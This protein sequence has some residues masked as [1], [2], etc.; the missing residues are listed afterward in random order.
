MKYILIVVAA[1]V[2]L[3]ATVVFLTMFTHIADK[4]ER[5]GHFDIYTNPKVT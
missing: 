5:A 2:G 3:M 1:A 4:H